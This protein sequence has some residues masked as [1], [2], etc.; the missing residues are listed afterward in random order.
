MFSSSSSSDDDDDDNNNNKNNKLV[1]VK[2]K[3]PRTTKL[4]G[5]AINGKR[6]LPSTNSKLM[7]NNQYAKKLPNANM[8]RRK[9]PSTVPEVNRKRVYASKSRA[10]KRLKATELN[11]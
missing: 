8:G 2:K 5:P 1:E 7:M 10:R 4:D 3:K 6:K 11:I 9:P